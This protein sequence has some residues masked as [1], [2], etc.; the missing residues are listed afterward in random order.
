M[1][2][3]VKLFSRNF[4]DQCK[5]NFIESSIQ[6]INKKYIRMKIF[7][8]SIF[9]VVSCVQSFGQ[10][11]S[12]N[13]SINTSRIQGTN[14]QVFKSLGEVAT[15]FFNNTVFTTHVYNAHERIECNILLDI[16]EASSADNYTARLQVQARRPVY[17]T[18][19]NTVLL[20]YVD[21]DIKFEYRE[22]DPIVYTENIFVS[23]LSSIFSFYSMFI[24]GLDYDSFS[25]KGGH[26][27]FLRAESIVASAQGSGYEGW[28]SGDSRA[29][30][31]RY[32]LISNMLDSEYQPLRE[33]NY[34]YHIQGL[35]KME[36][37]IREGRMNLF[38]SVKMLER[39]HNNKPDPFLGLLQVFVD[40][41][42]EEISNIFS[43]SEKDEKQ[44]VYNIMI[45]I[46]PAGGSKYEKLK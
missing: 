3:T 7:L 10:E 24:I 23:N 5:N 39:F 25:K 30:K 13:V 28:E 15:D 34:R 37:S 19:Y 18:T 11:L 22:S 43:E 36:S 4:A 41:K 35:D 42:S 6:P 27:Y 26:P 1:N 32:W 21:E 45:K 44:K 8:L 33:F 2:R 14:K 38:E 12:C 9:A 40:S 46:D 17:G 31:N 16:Q 29:R 20:N